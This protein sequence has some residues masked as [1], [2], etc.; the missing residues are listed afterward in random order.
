MK[1]RRAAL[2]LVTAVGV[3]CLALCWS[4][5]AQAQVKLQHKFPEGKKLTYK[6]TSKT[7]QVLTLMG[8]EIESEENST[9][10]FSL[11]AGKRR[12]DSNLPVE[13]KTESLH[14]ELSL[15]GGNKLAY[16]SSD[17]N[18]KIDN[19]ALAFLG[20]LF[21]LASGVVYTIVLDDQNKVKATEGTEK[22]QEK[23]DKLEPMARDLVRSQFESNKLKRAF[24]Q[25]LHIVP[26]VLARPGEPWERTEILELGGGQTLSF[27]K[28]YEYVGTEKKGTRR[29]TGSAAR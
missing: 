24:E 21:K 1:I 3:G 20:D 5:T 13:R 11:T 10:V 17:P 16:D 2:G 18:V 7:R 26:D 23:A 28:K 8:M 22:L 9:I 4:R 19:Q 15:P 14:A 27:R 6:T 12:G 29:W 25:E